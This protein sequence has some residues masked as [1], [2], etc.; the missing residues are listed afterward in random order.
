MA[1]GFP[2]IMMILFVIVSHTIQ[3]VASQTDSFDWSS[4]NVTRTITTSPSTPEPINANRTSSILDDTMS[5]SN[6]SLKTVYLTDTNDT[7]GINCQYVSDLNTSTTECVEPPSNE[8]NMTTG[9]DVVTL[10]VRGVVISLIAILG[11][12]GNCIA[13]CVLA[14]HKMKSPNSVILIF[15]AFFDSLIL[16]RHILMFAISSVLEEYLSPERVY[17]IYR[18]PLGV[19]YRPFEH[20]GYFG[21]IYTTVLLTFER[22]VVILFPLRSMSLCTIRHAR[23]SG[24]VILILA[25]VYNI[26]KFILGTIHTEEDQ[27][28]HLT[29][30]VFTKITF[31]SGMEFFFKQVYRKYVDKIVLLAFPAI[32]LV[33]L[34]GCILYKLWQKSRHFKKEGSAVFGRRSDGTDKLTAMML[35]II[36]TFCITLV[37]LQFDR[38]LCLMGIAGGGTLPLKCFGLHLTSEFMY[39]FNSAINFVYYCLFGAKFRK[40]LISLCARS[41]SSRTSSTTSTVT[42]TASNELSMVSYK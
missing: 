20:V 19:I 36:F 12:V 41:V 30:F 38:N 21:S 40:V 26:P 5:L 6:T 16:L 17:E 1:A 14:S 15:L 8:T 23:I 10:V 37:V 27:T 24:V 7:T 25:V 34:N 35:A 28:T 39:T 11:L 9:L 31:S 33:V 42:R 29:K 22:F 32:T 13:V 3:S 18:I 4:A 2:V